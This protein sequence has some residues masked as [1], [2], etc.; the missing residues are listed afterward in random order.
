MKQVLIRKG[1]AIV[2]EVPAPGCEAGEV[3]VRVRVSCLSVGTEMS[4]VRS[5]GMPLWK[6]VLQKP[7]KVASTVQM[8]ATQG[9]RRTWSMVEEKLDE[10]NPTGYSAAG[11]VVEVGAGIRDIA[12]G[13]RVACAGAQC[14]YHAEFIRV[15]RNL[16]VPLPDD[17]D[18]ESASTVTLGAIAL[19]G[20]RR[21]QPTLGE[22]FVVIGLGLLG[23]LTVQLL[24]ANGCRTIGIDLDR[25]RVALA[26]RAV[27][28]RVHV[29]LAA[30][31][32][33]MVDE[34]PVKSSSRASPVT[35]TLKTPW[36]PVSTTLNR[37]GSC[38][39]ASLAPGARSVPKS[40]VKKNS[41]VWVSPAA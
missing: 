29:L 10:A 39:E 3:L 21:A 34:D 37:K 26:R 25:D 32:P 38:A 23:Q 5:S 16:C 14:A 19:Q 6:R 2:G 18:W 27:H 4:G 41:S 7:E 8:L 33:A 31:R 35:V 1:S 9:V 20:V 13:D 30:L 22:S 36:S 17:V 15:S 11:V 24:H 40:L 12:P 28:E